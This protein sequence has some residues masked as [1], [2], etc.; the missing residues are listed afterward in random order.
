MHI[1]AWGTVSDTLG[2]GEG[3][4][5]GRHCLLIFRTYSLISRHGLFLLLRIIHTEKRAQRGQVTGL[6]SHGQYVAML[7]LKPGALSPRSS[8]RLPAMLSW[9]TVSLTERL[10]R[11]MSSSHSW[12]AT[13]PGLEPRFRPRW[14]WLC[15]NPTGRGRGLVLIHHTPT[16]HAATA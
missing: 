14:A 11:M 9:I 12:W 7:Q 2:G 4:H 15:Q 3:R 8:L 10:A 6:R 1:T 16:S 13:E 5:N